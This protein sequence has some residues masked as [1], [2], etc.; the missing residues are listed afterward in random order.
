MK[1]ETTEVRLKKV[2][3]QLWREF[4]SMCALKGI[5]VTT[6]ILQLITRD[7]VEFEVNK[8]KRKK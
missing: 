6:R 8:N 2:P 7:M 5:G 1:E 3:A 4:K